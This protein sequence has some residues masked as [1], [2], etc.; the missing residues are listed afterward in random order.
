MNY[1]KVLGKSFIYILSILFISTIIITLLNYINFFGNKLVTL[2]KIIVPIVSIFVGGFIIGK[3]SKQKGWLEGLKLGMIII[4][5]LLILNYI[6]LKQRW[7]LRN[8]VYYLILLSSSIFGSMVG[9]NKKIEEK[10]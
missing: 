5:I 3:N 8:L 6:I 7:E 2:S 4:L 1:L 10:K 9:I